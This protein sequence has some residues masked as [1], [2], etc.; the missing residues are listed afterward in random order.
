MPDLTGSKFS[1][2][3]T[4][5]LL[6][7]YKR[8]SRFPGKLLVLKLT[9]RCCLSLLIL[10]LTNLD[11]KWFQGHHS[12]NKSML[13]KFKERKFYQT[14]EVVIII[15][16]V[17]TVIKVYNPVLSCFSKQRVK[18]KSLFSACESHVLHASVM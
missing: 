17:G 1:V 12:A 5:G 3:S 18:R 11:N 16:A 9:G 4:S 10:D 7:M 6:H 14:H 8:N 2:R 15:F 13:R